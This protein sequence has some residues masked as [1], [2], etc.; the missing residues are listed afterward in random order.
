VPE[1][2]PNRSS[3]AVWSLSHTISREVV[4]TTQPL[5]RASWAAVAMHACSSNAE[6]NTRATQSLIAQ[7]EQTEAR[8]GERRKG[9]VFAMV[10]AKQH[11]PPKRNPKGACMN[12]WIKSTLGGRRW[13]CCWCW[14]WCLGSGR[15]LGFA[16]P[17]GGDECGGDD[18]SVAVNDSDRSPS[19]GAVVDEAWG[20]GVT[21]RA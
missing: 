5:P 15:G 12:R 7:D 9:T 1:S 20:G 21:C 8:I 2:L 19:L 14:C 6:R 17:V 10:Q 13:R 3:V 18:A 16:S 11:N 4:V